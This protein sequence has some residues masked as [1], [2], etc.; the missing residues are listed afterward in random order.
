MAVH[1]GPREHRGK[2]LK[3]VQLGPVE[4]SL[5]ETNCYSYAAARAFRLKFALQRSL[6]SLAR[7]GPGP[8]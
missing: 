7:D 2:P 4:D 5:I 6:N 8:V 1:R 3:M